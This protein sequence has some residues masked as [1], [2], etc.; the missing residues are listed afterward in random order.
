M[1]PILI[2]SLFLL[3]ALVIVVTVLLVTRRKTEPSHP[4]PAPTKTPSPNPTTP[5]AGG[6]DVPRVFLPLYYSPESPGKI[7]VSYTPTI[8]DLESPYFNNTEAKMILQLLQNFEH[9]FKEGKIVY[10]DRDRT[11]QNITDTLPFIGESNDRIGVVSELLPVVTLDLFGNESVHCTGYILNVNDRIGLNTTLA[12]L[13][14][15]ETDNEAELVK[16]SALRKPSWAG[17]KNIMVHTGFSNLYHNSS[18]KD[19]KM[20]RDVLIAWIDEVLNTNPLANIEVAGYAQ[21]AALTQLCGADLSIKYAN[22]VA[23][24]ANLQFLCFASPMVGDAQFVNV[25]QNVSSL[26]ITGENYSGVFNVLNVSDPIVNYKFNSQYYPVSIQSFCFDWK[27]NPHS[28]QAYLKG[29][30]DYGEAMER[31][32]KV[33]G[34]A[35]NVKCGWM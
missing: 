25:L 22:S 17:D 2:I 11:I 21:G 10:E 6:G 5:P 7:K 24:R 29:L 35:G 26:P 19:H 8:S 34:T 9:L 31:N 13:G 15:T 1:R 18:I 20:L 33:V 16:L 30:E 23:K 32:G 28:F 3:L 4:S 14:G 12:L 27:E